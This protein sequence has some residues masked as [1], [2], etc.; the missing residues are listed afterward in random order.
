MAVVDEDRRALGVK[1]HEVV[2]DAGRR[3]V[4]HE[5]GQ[6]IVVCARHVG[7]ADTRFGEGPADG[8]HRRIVQFEE[9]LARSAPVILRQIGFVPGFEIPCPDLI[10]AITID[11]MPDPLIDQF[12]PFGVVPGGIGPACL[13]VVEAGAPG[14][15]VRLRVGGQGLR[16]EAQFDVRLDAALQVGVEDAVDDGP[17]IDR[18]AL[19]VFGVDIGRSPL[20][21]RRAVAAGH[22][23]MRAEIDVARRQLAKIGQQGAAVF[24]GGV[25]RLVGTEEAPDRLG[26]ADDVSGID[27]YRNRKTV[28]GRHAG[29]QA[30]E[31][32]DKPRAQRGSREGHGRYRDQLIFEGC[33][34]FRRAL[35]D[36]ALTANG[37]A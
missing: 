4:F 16:H 34:G 35:A 1:R 30:Q 13:E 8:A 23:I 25:V 31:K 19:G 7:A 18:P 14:V 2:L 10:A 29:R 32:A 15:L 36:C 12:V 21:G 24:H 6:E 33:R 37:A 17:A 9:F 22:E 27:M 26:L 11:A 20:Q 5:G 28:L 3:F